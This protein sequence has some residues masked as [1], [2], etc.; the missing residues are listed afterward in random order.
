ME[1]QITT[2]MTLT[3]PSSLRKRKLVIAAAHQVFIEQGYGNASM[4]R[5][6]EV[7]GVSKR[8]VYNHFEGKYELFS[9]VIMRLCENV[10]PSS[11]DT[12]AKQNWSQE[13][14]LKW[15]A[16]NFLRHIYTSEQ[17]ELYRTIVAESRNFPELGIQFFDGPVSASERVIY[18]YLVS[19][20][21]ITGLSISNPSLAASHFMGMLKSDM[22]MKLLL[23]K[24]KRI[25]PAEIEEIAE[26]AVGLFLNGARAR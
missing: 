9:A 2:R 10:M 25:T 16:V 23:G 21:N 15:L 8:T 26:S 7:A 5:I 14:Y 19:Q 20:T 11:A 1:A 17:I 6:A 12:K 18:D 4:D 3:R 24:R 22:Q 13:D